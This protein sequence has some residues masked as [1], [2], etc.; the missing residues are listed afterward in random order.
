MTIAVLASWAPNLYE[1]YDNTQEKLLAS[2]PRLMRPFQ[3]SVFSAVTY[4]LGP[5]TV[6]FPH[7]DF[8]NL[9]FGWC[10]LVALGKFDHT[11]GGHLVLWDCRLVIEFPPGSTIL[12]PSALIAHSN[13]KIG[14]SETRYSF[15]S[16]TAGG[17]FRWVDHGFQTMASFKAGL[18]VQEKSDL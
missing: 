2:D 15:T 10:A 6:C 14:P 13:T 11:K 18:S 17:L 9:P 4:N 12:F 1:Y 5:S 16:Y 8:A 3:R 7:T